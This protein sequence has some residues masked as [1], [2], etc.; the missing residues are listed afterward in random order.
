M[1]SITYTYINNTLLC[2]RR[3]STNY[4]C[5]GKFPYVRLMKR[6]DLTYVRKMVKIYD[7]HARIVY[8]LMV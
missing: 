5:E 1:F 7:W 8:H 4:N 6:C 3:F 2:Y